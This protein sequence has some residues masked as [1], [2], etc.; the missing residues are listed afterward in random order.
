MS[1]ISPMP[2]RNGVFFVDET[3]YASIVED[4]TWDNEMIK[5]PVEHKISY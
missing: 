1:T 5:M 2:L 4:K 3:W